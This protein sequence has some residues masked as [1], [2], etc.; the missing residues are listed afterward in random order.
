MLYV[1]ITNLNNSFMLYASITNLNN[2]YC[3]SC[4]MFQL[5]TSKTFIEF[6]VICLN[7][8]RI[9]T[10]NMKLNKCYSG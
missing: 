6:H 8:E 7:Y 1:S 4:Y 3:V 9:E 5:R 10:Y 2:I